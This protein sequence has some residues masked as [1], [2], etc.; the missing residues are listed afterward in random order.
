[1]AETKILVVDD[2]MVV[3][4]DGQNRLKS[5]GYS[6]IMERKLIESEKW[7]AAILNNIGDAVI[8]TDEK[9]IIKL[10]NP[11]AEALTGWSKNDSVGKP[12]KVIFNI[13]DEKTGKE[14]E[15]P[16][17]KVW[18]EGAF[19]GLSEHAA[20]HN[21]YGMEIP[22]DIIGTPVLDD[23]N[24]IIG[25]IF[26]FYDILERK[27]MECEGFFGKGWTNIGFNRSSMPQRKLT[28]FS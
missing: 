9:G 23:R 25:M 20:L 17:I 19:F 24:K 5:Y 8:A 6:S 3:V 21:R 14:A 15:N 11:F 1:M 22:V 16:V 12:L 13:I 10:I 28:F 7:Q 2:E 26:V 27:K 4:K 18:R